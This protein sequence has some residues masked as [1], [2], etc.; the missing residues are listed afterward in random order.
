MNKKIISVAVA[1]AIITAGFAGCSANDTQATEQTVVVTQAVTDANGEDVTDDNGETVVEAVTDE[2][3]EKVTEVVTTT[4]TNKTGDS[5]TTTTKQQTKST[6]KAVSTTKATTKKATTKATTT[7][8]VDDSIAIVLQK[9]RKVSCSSP[10]VSLSTGQVVIEKGGNYVITSKTDDWH[11]E[12]IVKLKNTEKCNIRFEGTGKISNNSKNII[13]ILDNSIKSNRSFLEAEASAGTEAENELSDVADNDKAPNVDISFPTGSNWQLQSSANSYTGVIYN[14][15]KLTIK[16]NGKATI[17]SIRN[18]NNC[19]CSTKSITIKNVALTLTTAQNTNTESLAKSSGSAKGI[20]SYSKVI[21]ESGSLTIK[22]NGDG[23][24]CQRFYSK[25]GSTNIASSACDGI[26]ADNSITISAGS[27]KAIAYEKFSFK[28]RRVN[29]SEEGKNENKKGKIIGVR[30]KKGDGFWINGG[31]VVGESKNISS[32]NKAYQ[33]DKK[34]S[35]QA[36]ITA[37]IVKKNTTES[38]KV[39]AIISITGINKTSA[40]ACIKYIY[41]SKS[42]SSSK[43]YTAKAKNG[44]QAKVKFTG[45]AGIAEIKTTSNK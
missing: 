31:T 18:A 16:G 9:N 2:D 39:P 15:S 23:I 11:G 12:I 5:S 24:R 28:V 34:D 29:N 17:A 1:V 27:V 38:S 13:Q 41:S 45:K 14:E 8:K 22:S 32:L 30:P 37:K 21:V 43:T 20:F 25:G 42:V 10:N 3:G 35:K 36:S 44:N 7:K 33:S 4:T 6:T 19:I 40:K 26:D